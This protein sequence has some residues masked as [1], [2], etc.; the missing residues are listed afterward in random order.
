MKDLDLY[1]NIFIRSS[2][3]GAYMLYKKQNSRQREEQFNPSEPLE[4][5]GIPSNRPPFPGA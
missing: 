1:W 5:T 2:S 3:P 4:T